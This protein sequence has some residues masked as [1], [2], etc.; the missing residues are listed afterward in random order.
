MNFLANAH[1]T[2]MKKQLLNHLHNLKNALLIR[3]S[4]LEIGYNY[5]I[6]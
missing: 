1:A 6:K 5:Q 3:H 4:C 2:T